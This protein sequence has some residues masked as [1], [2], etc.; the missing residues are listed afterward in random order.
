MRR[1]VNRK[2]YAVVLL[3]LVVSPFTAPFQS[4]DLAG[5]QANNRANALVAPTPNEADAGSLLAPL[6]TQAGRLKVTLAVSDLPGGWFPAIPAAL[7]MCL[8][9]PLPRRP[10][11][12]AALPTVLRV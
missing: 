3:V 7:S 10:E 6:V 12:G 2:F 11:S 4:Y 1:I 8:R 5:A 9:V